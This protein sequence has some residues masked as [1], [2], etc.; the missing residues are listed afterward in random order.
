[1]RRGVAT[2]VPAL[3]AVLAAGPLGAIP[4]TVGFSSIIIT[5]LAQT[6]QAGRSQDNLSGSVLAA[7][8]GSASVLVLSLALA[9]L[10]RF[11]GLRTPTPQ[12]IALSLATAPASVSLAS[13][14]SR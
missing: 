7:V 4:Q 13:R 3:S 5:Q 11:L 9:P 6:V 14:L 8:A 12:G 1:V 2:A 10:R